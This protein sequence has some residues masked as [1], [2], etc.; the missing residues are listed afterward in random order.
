ML[1]T[2]LL[3]DVPLMQVVVRFDVLET[4][5]FFVFA[6]YDA[7]IDLTDVF[8]QK[9]AL[10]SLQLERRRLRKV[11]VGLVVRWLIEYFT[12]AAAAESQK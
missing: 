3:T 12:I 4:F 7:L 9:T 11:F 2:V 6:D 8:L 10:L 5:V 1:E